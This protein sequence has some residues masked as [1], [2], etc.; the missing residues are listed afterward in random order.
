[1]KKKKKEMRMEQ[2]NNL[3]S[4]KDRKNMGTTNSSKSRQYSESDRINFSDMRRKDT[5]KNFSKYTSINNKVLPS[6][7]L[8]K[9]KVYTHDYFF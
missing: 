7:T 3:S 9:K 5:A 1:M 8:T 2:K 6:K 4:S